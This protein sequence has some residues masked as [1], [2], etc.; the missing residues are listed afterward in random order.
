MKKLSVLF[1]ALLLLATVA[2]EGCQEPAVVEDFAV[3]EASES[4]LLIAKLGE[5]GE[6]ME[7]MQYSM[8]NYFDPSVPISEGCVITVEHDGV[9]METYPMQFAKIYKVTHYDKES[10]RQTTVT[11]D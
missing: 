5:D 4:Y 1:L 9:A 8:P 10:G 6:V 7:G 11:P 3:L 2:L